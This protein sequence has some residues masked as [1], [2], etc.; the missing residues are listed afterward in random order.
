MASKVIITYHP[1]LSGNI[2]HLRRLIDN[3]NQALT[4]VP[5]LVQ[6][7]DILRGHLLVQRDVDGL[8]NPLKPR[9]H[10]WNK[11]NLCSQPG[12][13]LPL[14]YVIGKCICHEIVRQLGDIVLRGRLSAST[15]VSRD[16]KNS[17]LSTKEWNERGNCELG[18][19]RITARVGNAGSFRNI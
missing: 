14:V 7:S 12:T 16:A 8:M 4:C 11:A 3:L 5:F 10:M 15:R 1:V 13:D 9:S 2:L 18:S 19:S 17:W 6:G